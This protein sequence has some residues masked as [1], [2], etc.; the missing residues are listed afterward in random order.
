MFFRN[1]CTRAALGVAAAVVL[2][3][4]CSETLTPEPTEQ[5]TAWYAPT[6]GAVA[7]FV[8]SDTTFR[9]AT[10]TDFDTLVADY[11]LRETVGGSET[12]A[13]GR[14]L[15]Q[16]DRDTAG[17][18][19]GPFTFLDRY[20]VYTDNLLAERLEG[21]LRTVPLQNPVAQD[22]EWDGNRYNN[23]GEQRYRYLDTDTTVTVNGQTYTGCLFVLQ[24]QVTGSLLNED[25]TYEIYAP[26]LGL[27]E[28]YDRQLRYILEEGGRGVDT[29]NSRIEHRLRL[30]Q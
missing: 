25:L 2:G 30:P 8:A 27:I 11:V 12:D 18:P 4:G 22:A 28:R 16:V 9:F 13:Q 6:Q 3:T 24:R 14:T 26:G 7:L 17:A 10:P 1:P 15:R 21:N 23:L 29:D 20:R 19:A 5:F